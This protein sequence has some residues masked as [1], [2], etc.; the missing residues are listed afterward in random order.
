M[1]E[2][3][4]HKDIPAVVRSQQG[5][6]LTAVADR[7]LGGCGSGR[8]HLWGFVFTLAPAAVVGCEGLHCRW[9]PLWMQ[10]EHRCTGVPKVFVL[11]EQGGTGLQSL[12]C[13]ACYS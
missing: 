3:V 6:R 10:E 9:H 13:H 8:Q 1:T 11:E 2:E 5:V 4:P 12:Q 7:F